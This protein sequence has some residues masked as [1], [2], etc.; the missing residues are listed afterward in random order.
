MPEPRFGEIRPR[1]EFELRECIPR[2]M[3]NHRSAFVLKPEEIE[4]PDTI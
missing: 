4:A 1:R 2:T 3:R